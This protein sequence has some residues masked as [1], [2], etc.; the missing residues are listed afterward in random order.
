MFAV[1][2]SVKQVNRFVTQ[3]ESTTLP[4]VRLKNN[5]FVLTEPLVYMT[6]VLSDRDRICIPKGFRSDLASIPRLVR[7]MFSVAGWWRDASWPHDFCCNPVDEDMNPIP[8]FC[9]HDD[10]TDVWFEAMMNT[11]GV[12]DLS[13][14]KRKRKK[15]TARFLAWIVRK[16][17][18]KFEKGDIWI[19]PNIL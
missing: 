4:G 17:G 12:M 11:V 7:W 13:L 5:P 2:K 1:L 3:P 9:D 14:K 19:K 8:H 16:H 15:R 6:D 18:P 10:A